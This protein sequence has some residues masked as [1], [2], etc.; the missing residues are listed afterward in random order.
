MVDADRLDPSTVPGT[1]DDIDAQTAALMEEL[2]RSVGTAP[3]AV[4]SEPSGS[5]PAS[6]AVPVPGADPGAD[7]T[8]AAF[9]DE[10]S[11]AAEPS[12]AVDDGRG[13][14]LSALGIS[15]PQITGPLDRVAEPVDSPYPVV[16]MDPVPDPLPAADLDAA[17]V[18]QEPTS[19]SGPGNRALPSEE[20]KSPPRPVV[21]PDK[22]LSSIDD[23]LDFE[24]AVAGR[25]GRFPSL[26]LNLL[27]LAGIVL[28]LATYVGLSREAAGATFGS[29]GVYDMSMYAVAGLAAL[30]LILLIPL[31]LVARKRFVRDNAVFLQ[32]L[33]RTVLVIAVIAGLW[34]L[35][36]TAAQTWPL[37]TP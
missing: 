10:P 20:L 25:V 30:G 17:P 3:A 12:E 22:P 7:G 11:T 29:L 37:V 4:A 33:L 28:A 31:W 23:A 6:E 1:S 5:E 19:E 2:L 32:V 21:F 26:P 18:A 16:A 9:T 35:S 15:I 27:L 34:F 36:V 14:G 24:Q 13:L 8:V